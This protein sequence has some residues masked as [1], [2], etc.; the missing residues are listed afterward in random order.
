MEEE[1]HDSN[2]TISKKMRMEAKHKLATSYNGLEIEQTESYIA[3]WV[4]KYIN[5]VA[6]NH[7]WENDV[8]SK[9]PKAPPLSNTMAKEIIESGKGPL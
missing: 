4:E 9:K 1:Y 3:N 5:K 2:G 7:G 6:A 8:F